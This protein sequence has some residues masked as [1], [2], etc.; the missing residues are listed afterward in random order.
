MKKTILFSGILVIVILCHSC[1]FFGPSVK[2]DGNVTEQTR[3]ISGFEKIE[4]STGLEVSLIPDS[5]EYV[6]VESDANLHEH[7]QTELVHHTL[8]IYTESRIRWA[9][10]KKVKVHYTKLAELKSSSGAMVRSEAPIVT[11]AIELHASSGSQQHLEIEARKIE[12]RCSSGA[13]IYV[14]GKC[15][16]AE[17]KASSGAHLKGGDLWTKNCDADVSSGAHIW[18]AVSDELNAEASSGGHV[19]YSGEPTK[20]NVHSS[21]GGMISRN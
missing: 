15:E 21:S 10:A 17:L 7:I 11:K 6:V 12:G 14:S 8:R 5:T 9:K 1:I 20:T 4:A 16:T 19:F 13:H 18:I 3:Q 2:G